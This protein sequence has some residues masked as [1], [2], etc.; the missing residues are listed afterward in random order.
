MI[1]PNHSLC[2]GEETKLD[3]LQC[4]PRSRNQLVQIDEGILI[5]FTCISMLKFGL[6]G[7]LK[8]VPDRR[9]FSR[10]P[11]GKK[12]L[13]KLKNEVWKGIFLTRQ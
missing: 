13:L 12:N 9:N 7:K 3:V 4:L 2:K 10:Y 6:D 1:W 8:L 11:V 5:V